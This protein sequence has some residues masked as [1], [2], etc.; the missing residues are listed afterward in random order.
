VRHWN[1]E[2]RDVGD[3]FS[4]EAFKERLDKALGSLMQLW[5]PCSLQ[6]IWTGWPSEV[7][8]NSTLRIL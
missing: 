6:R 4:L 8:S 5:C 3:A 7:P 2:P 1:R